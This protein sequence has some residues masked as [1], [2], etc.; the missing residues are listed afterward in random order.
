MIS[1]LVW[2]TTAWAQSY[3]VFLILMVRN[4]YRWFRNGILLSY[5]STVFTALIS[6]IL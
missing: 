5:S 1:H 3:D 4:I 6:D 2:S